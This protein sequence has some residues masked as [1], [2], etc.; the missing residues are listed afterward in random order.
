MTSPFFGLDIA[1]RALQTQQTLVDIAN[2][3]IANAN[4]PGYSRQSASVQATLAYPVP[5]FSASGQPGQMGTGVQVTAITRARDTFADMQIRGQMSEQGRWNSRQSALAQVEAAVNEPSATAVSGQ[6]TAYW[7]SWQEL[8]NNPSDSAARVS[9]LQHGE[10]LAQAF[11]GQAQQLTQQQQNLDSNI[12]LTVTNINDYATQISQLNVQISQAESG[13]MHAN[14]L[15]DQRDQLMDKLSSLVK[16]TSSETPDGQIGL[17]INGHQLVFGNQVHPLVANPSPGPWTTVQWKDD[18]TTLNTASAGGQIQ[19]LTEARDTDVQNQLNNLNQLAARMIQ[20]VNAVQTAGVGL[21]GKGGQVFFDGTNA[22]NMTVDPSLTA[23]NGTDHI[24][25]ARMYADPTS[26]TGYSF[27]TG[28]SS[29]AVAVADL[30]NQMGQLSSTSGIQTGTSYSGPPATT[31]VGADASQA[32][33]NSTISLSVS[34]GTVTFSN[35]SSTTSGSVTVGSDSSGNE[36]V[37]VDGGSLGVRLTLSAAAGTPVNT[38]LANLNGRS[39]STQSA[40]TTIDRQYSQ[41]VAALGVTSQTAQNESTNQQ[42]LVNQLNTQ[43]QTVSGV[44]L[45]EEATQ[46]IQYQRAYEAAARVISVQDSMLDTLI[47][48]TGVH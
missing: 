2:Q 5:V 31:V 6:M 1:T 40:P 46:L 30:Q 20:Q 22:L 45:D 39:V 11:N 48:N 34:G 42:V 37:T 25:A 21:D 4:T 3:N 23:T 9:V 36:L 38:I 18:G 17:Y 44:S 41:A 24:A 35:G 32:A 8:A 26:S 28:D 10:A 14:D 12:G 27:A 16:V 43:R 13:G 47:N 19:G 33:V 15:R 29:N 7:Q